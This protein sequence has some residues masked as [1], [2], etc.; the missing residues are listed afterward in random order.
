MEQGFSPEGFAPTAAAK[1]AGNALSRATRGGHAPAKST[2]P[3]N[4]NAAA[5]AVA[6]GTA[7]ASDVAKGERQAEESLRGVQSKL[8]LPA[9]VSFIGMPVM[10]L[11]KK[12]P[13]ER[14][15]TVIGSVFTAS[16]RALNKT[17]ISDLGQLPANYMKAVA[18]QAKTSGAEQWAASAFETS[19]GLKVT[20]EA[21]Q[22]KV[23]EFIKPVTS[24]VSGVVE[25]FGQTGFAKAM[26][27][28]VKNALGKVRGASV[29]QALMV[30]GVT[31]GM[32]AT[33]M[34]SRA[35]K[36]ETKAAF[37]NLMTDIGGNENSSF[38]KAVKQTYTSQK[39]WG[40]G[41]TGIELVGGVVDGVMWAKPGLGGMAMMGAMMVPQLAQSLVPESPTLGAYVALGKAD[42]GEIKLDAAARTDLVKQLVAVMPTVAAN[43]GQYNRLVT[44]VAKEM[45]SKNMTAK[46]VVQLLNNDQ[47]F[48]AL[49]G[50]VSAKQQ[51]A[52]AALLKDQP[53][54]AEKPAISQEA[55]PIQVVGEARAANQP[56][57]KLSSIEHQGTVN[58]RELLRA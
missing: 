28:A 32:A 25:K 22:G 51:A 16:T 11:A 52:K 31:A 58:S 41:K 49:A 13:M 23:A 2:A 54:H 7:L 57:M 1:Q 38:A 35:E 29:F 45:V 27:S 14:T 15:K 55:A 36:K 26:P 6:K 33:L 17:Q 24:A 4:V 8:M 30:A 47:A 56:S 42:A 12:L 40:V 34:G 21:V 39:K 43:G 5:E 9:M 18:S 19:K 53:K 37:D 20:G 46:Q 10:W 48:T 3:D 44:P 50:E